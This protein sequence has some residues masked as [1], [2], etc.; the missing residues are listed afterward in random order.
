M[1]ANWQE[2]ALTVLKGAI[3]G[4]VTVVLGYAKK[5]PPES[6]DWKALITKVPLGI[7]VGAIAAY[8]QIPFESAMAWATAVGV[9]TIVDQVVKAVA[10][11]VCPSL[12]EK[13][14]VRHVPKASGGDSAA[15]SS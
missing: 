11:R 13:L 14:G 8:Q 5:V 2:I 1:D 4:I 9:V 7:V 10:R 15:T 3:A 6:F 12:A